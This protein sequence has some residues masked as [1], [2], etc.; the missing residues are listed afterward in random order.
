MSSHQL[1]RNLDL[2]Q[3]TAWYLAMRI[4]RA[5]AEKDGWLPA[6]TG[7]AGKA[8]AGGKSPTTHSGRDSGESRSE[9]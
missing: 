9:A 8:C 4:R 6:G 5:M 7:K 3:K 2:N 1:A